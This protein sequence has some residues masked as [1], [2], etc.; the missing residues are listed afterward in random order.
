MDIKGSGILR[1][2]EGFIR[3]NGKKRK[4]R[5]DSFFHPII[6]KNFRFSE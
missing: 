4:N 1:D 6:L 2:F 5:K 3:N